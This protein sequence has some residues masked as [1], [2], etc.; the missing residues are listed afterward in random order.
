MRFQMTEAVMIVRQ[1]I[2]GAAILLSGALVSAQA[3][4]EAPI[5]EPTTEDVL[6]TAP[7]QWRVLG[8][9]KV[10]GRRD[11]GS[12]LDDT[13]PKDAERIAFLPLDGDVLCERISVSFED[14]HSAW[15]A[16]GDAPVFKEGSLYAFDLRVERGD[17]DNELTRI[18]F[19]CLTAANT[20]VMMQVLG[21]G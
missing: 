3:P 12:A 14:G 10:Q 18:N 7:G 20:A 21:S 2:R 19:T 16:L 15:L 5:A 1:I 17:Q 6:I 4:S 11:E 13:G 8:T 9:E